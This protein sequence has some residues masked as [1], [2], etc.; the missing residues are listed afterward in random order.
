MFLITL[1]IG[2]SDDDV[3][4]DFAEKLYG[5]WSTDTNEDEIMYLTFNRNGTYVF[6]STFMGEEDYRDT[7]NWSCTENTITATSKGEEPETVH[8]TMPDNNTLVL[9]LQVTYYR[10]D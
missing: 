4:T 8:Y 6:Y 9:E 10:I 7:G 2:C 1:L 3:Q 5:S